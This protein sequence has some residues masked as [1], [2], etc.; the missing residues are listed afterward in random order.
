MNTV[1]I[2]EDEK[3]I[4][5]FMAKALR[6]E[7]Y[8]VREAGTADEG[9]AALAGET[10]DVI[11]LDLGL[12]DRDGFSL[13]RAVRREW[14]LP[15]I[16]VSARGDEEDK[17]RA[18]DCG[19]DDYMT[20]PFGTPELMA[21]IRAALRRRPAARERKDGYAVGEFRI[22]FGRRLVTVRG[23]EIHLTANEYK[24]VETL[25]RNA[26]RV[27][28]YESLR[29]TLWKKA[30][31]DG[32]RVLRVNMA[33]IRRKIEPD[34]AEPRYIETEVGVGYRMAEEGRE[35]PGTDSPGD[36]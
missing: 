23:E 11:L 13:L 9:M 34:P 10:A 32:N 18:L 29:K 8:A 31:G 35:P 28:T 20:K 16:V 15:V 21:R 26:G 3:A 4:R 5:D 7:G 30:P 27:I 36:A 14:D 22:D 19:A 33:N 12:P 1:L 17:V 24:I 6:D 2:V 25:S